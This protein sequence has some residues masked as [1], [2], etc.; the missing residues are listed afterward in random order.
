VFTI[1]FERAL[2]LLAAP[3]KA[4]RRQAATKTV[5][6]E[7]GPHPDTNAPVRVLA[8]RYG[9]YVT[10]GTTNASLPRGLEPPSVTLEIAVG[11]LAARAGA[12]PSRRRR[13][14]RSSAPANAASRSKKAL[15][16]VR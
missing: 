6:A 7:L 4:R 14:R 3:K 15:A 11:L 12:A 1:S 13:T 8:G 5:L 16:T 2:A 9:P 10:D